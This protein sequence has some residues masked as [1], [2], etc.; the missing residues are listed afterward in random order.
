MA[1]TLSAHQSTLTRPTRPNVG[2]NGIAHATRSG[3][4]TAQTKADRIVTKAAW[5]VW[6]DAWK[7]TYR[8]SVDHTTAFTVSGSA[9]TYAG[10]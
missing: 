1:L 9:I 10:D 4:T 7:A 2:A 5:V 3:G 8:S 6:S